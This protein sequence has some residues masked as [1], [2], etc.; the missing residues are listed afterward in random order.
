MQR[1]ET[2]HLNSA[3]TEKLAWPQYKISESSLIQEPK[4]FLVETCGTTYE[5]LFDGSPYMCNPEENLISD[6]KEWLNKPDETLPKI[7]NKE[8]LEIFWT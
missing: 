8:M 6:I 2:I 3:N 7:T 4:R 1:Q 5:F